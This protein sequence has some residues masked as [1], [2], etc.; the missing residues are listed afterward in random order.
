MC[1]EVEVSC[2]LP[3]SPLVHTNACLASERPNPTRPL[4]T[5][6][7]KE[8]LSLAQMQEQT[9][10]L[11]QQSK[12]KVGSGCGAS[13][14][15]PCGGGTQDGG[16]WAQDGSFRRLLSGITLLLV[17]KREIRRGQRCAGFVAWV[18][19]AERPGRAGVGEDHLVSPG[20]SLTGCLCVWQDLPVE[21]RRIAKAWAL[22][23]AIGCCK[24]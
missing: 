11:E 15:G 22:P 19:A 20:E 21:Q 8:A 16:W 23:S 3:E 14:G 17:V 4:P 13:G 24:V 10:Q 7:A 18:L 5:G 2:G 1:F 12:L 6:H 9:L